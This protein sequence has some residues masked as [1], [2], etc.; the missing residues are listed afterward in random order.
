[1]KRRQFLLSSSA[2]AAAATIAKPALAQQA[3]P[4]AKPVT[5]VVA[6]A[7]GGSADLVARAVAEVANGRATVF[8]GSQ[9]PHYV[10]EGVAAVTG[11]KAEDVH[12]VWVPGP[13][14]YGRNDAGD[15]A[16]LLSTRAPGL[17]MPAFSA[18]IAR[19]HSPT[20]SVWSRPMLVTTATI[21]ASL[22]N[23]PSLSSLST[24]KKSLLPSLALVPPIMPTRPPT[25]MVGS[26]FA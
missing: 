18:A 1:M 12:V 7:P 23:D 20:P 10:C 13:G 3:W 4:L 16:A 24:T 5:I 17:M 14:S 11:L 6:V 15:A 9:K 21:G 19:R 2:A 22:R 8:T 26:S 25:T